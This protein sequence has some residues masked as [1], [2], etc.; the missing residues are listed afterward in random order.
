MA[1]NEFTDDALTRAMAQRDRYAAAIRKH[2]HVRGDDRCYV[3]D[4]ELYA[5]LPEGDVRPSRESAVTAENCARFI[6]LRQDG[7]EREYVSPQRRIDEL[8]AEVAA[9]R[10]ELERK[11]GG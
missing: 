2:M 7:R 5:V 8:E 1:V 9:L 3:D 6:H 10:A 11:A 4:A